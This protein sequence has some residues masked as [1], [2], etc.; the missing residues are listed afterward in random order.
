MTKS[1]S[2]L[3]AATPAGAE[4][5][6]LA[7]L[8]ATVSITRTDISAQ[9]SDNSINTAGGNFVT[10]GFAVGMRCRVQGFTGNVVNN[11]V[12]GELTAVAA[13]K[14]TF[15]GV[16]GDVIVDDAAGES[17]TITAYESVQA[18]V[19]QVAQLAPQWLCIAC[20]DEATPLTTG[21]A[22]VKFHWPF[23]GEVLEV[24]AGLSATQPSGST[25]T[26]DLNDGGGSMLSTKITI[27]NGEETSLTSAAP[28]VLSDTSVVKGNPAT[29]DIDQVGAS[30]AAGLKVYIKLRPAP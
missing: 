5:M 12:A 3:A 10:A 19:L 14:L 11:L 27:D 25:L 9:A 29:V 26:V 28:P 13:G 22:K 2:Q 23:S 30:G 8:S 24:F 1:I 18:S 7:K 21:A 20:S 16:D 6:E 17:V 4:L 15:G